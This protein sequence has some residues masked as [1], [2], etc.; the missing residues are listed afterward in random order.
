MRIALGLAFHMSE[1]CNPNTTTA[2]I[3]L[4]LIP[5]QALLSI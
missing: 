3:I 4:G 1:K 5:F 2:S